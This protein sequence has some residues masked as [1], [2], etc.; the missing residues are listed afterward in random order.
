MVITMAGLAKA[1]VG[2]A[3]AEKRPAIMSTFSAEQLTIMAQEIGGGVIR[4]RVGRP[5]HDL[6]NEIR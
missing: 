1:C 3:L 4:G 5:G 2:E 6:L